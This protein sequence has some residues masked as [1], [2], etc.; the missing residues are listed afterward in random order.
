MHFSLA[1]QDCWN[2]MASTNA[3]TVTA[4]IFVFMILGQD[5]PKHD[6]RKT[7]HAVT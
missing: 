4:T 1:F 5:K 6:H 7:I 2:L 3:K